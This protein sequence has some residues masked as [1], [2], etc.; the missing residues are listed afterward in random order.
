MVDL[1]NTAQP[2]PSGDEAARLR[3]VLAALTDLCELQSSAEIL[4]EAVVRT[5]QTLTGASGAAVEIVQGETMVYAT[6]CGTL[7]S[8]K[9]LRLPRTGSLSGLC[10]S[11]RLPQ[12][13]RDTEH[14]P[15]V[16][17]EA[18]RRTGLRAMLLAPLLHGPQVLGALKVGADR[19][20]T[21]DAQ[22]AQT[23]RLLAGVIGGVLGKQLLVDENRRLLHE[24]AEAVA[25]AHAAAGKLRTVIDASPLAITVHD[26]R[27]R[28]LEWNP[29][30]ERLF[31]WRAD[32]VIG[33]RPPLESFAERRRFVRTMRR[34]IAEGNVAVGETRRPC[35]DGHWIDV[36]VNAA[37]L[38]NAEGRVVGVVR[39]HEDIGA[40]KE[41][42]ARLQ[43][44]ADRNRRIVERSIDAFVEIDQDSTV[45]EWNSRAELLFGWSREEAL[46]RRLDELVIPDELRDRYRENMRCYLATGESP[47]IGR[48]VEMEA[49]RRDGSRLTVEVLINAYRIG[50]R[51]LFDAF[52]HDVSE[53]R[54]EYEH[55]RRRA[56]YDPL[57]NLPNRY[58]FRDNL[59]RALLLAG[60]TPDRLAVAFIDIDDFKSINDRYGHDVGDEVL[61][62][63]ASRLRETVRPRDTVA[64]LAGDEFVILLEGLDSARIHAARIAEK[65]L[66]AFAAPCRIGGHELSIVLSIG[67]AVHGDVRDS[68]ETLLR[69]A[70]QAMYAAKQAGG[71]YRIAMR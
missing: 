46:G 26:L 20:D 10:V 55:L 39:T 7:A 51:H 42:Q 58:L 3:Q 33:H 15:R 14:D 60:D 31:G 63:T 44:V 9:G 24:L 32:E 35:R 38:R 29:A 16:D 45:T 6:A 66:A 5:A 56:L 2:L 28:V 57:T 64:R 36:R 22:D 41:Q 34:V 59:Q 62:T 13:S 37:A 40:L 65:V 53:R 17:R 4:M 19:P 11:S 69:R 21:F 1:P 48:R 61:C 68:L 47:V 54:R 49:V 8:F 12:S 23:L 18:A 25:D 30:A 43:A 52:L 70:D 67:V 27:G 71:G 50:D